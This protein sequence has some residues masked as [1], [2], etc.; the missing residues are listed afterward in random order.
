ML[1]LRRL[2]IISSGSDFTLGDL[3]AIASLRLVEPIYVAVEAKEDGAR[4]PATV[5]HSP[6][7]RIGIK[8]RR[9]EWLFN[10]ALNRFTLDLQRMGVLKNIPKVEQAFVTRG[11]RKRCYCRS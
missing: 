3:R 1:E 7:L 8:E 4:G 6:D 2:A 11:P 5:I 10:R 9:G